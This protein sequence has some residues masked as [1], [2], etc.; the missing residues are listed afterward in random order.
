MNIYITYSLWFVL[1][2]VLSLIGAIEATIFLLG[3]SILTSII[4]NNKLI[5][6]NYSMAINLYYLLVSFS[7]ISLIIFIVMFILYIIIILFK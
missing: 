3:L 2:L 5:M 4:F 1:G 6:A 7:F